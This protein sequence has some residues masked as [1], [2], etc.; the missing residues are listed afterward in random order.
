MTPAVA[1]GLSGPRTILS[2]FPKEQFLELK[3]QGITRYVLPAASKDNP[4]TLKVNDTFAWNRNWGVDEVVFFQQPVSAQVVAENLVHVWAA[5]MVGSKQGFGPGIM[6]IAGD[7]PTEEELE[8]VR[9][10]QEEFFNFLINTADDYEQKGE[11]HMI[12]DVH[13]KAAEWMGVQGRSWA[14]AMREKRYIPCPECQEDILEGARKCKH[15]QSV[16]VQSYIEPIAPP[17]QES[18]APPR[19]QAIKA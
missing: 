7:T 14:K 5:S 12:T 17:V 15:C 16:L 11:R 6:I 18:K 9:N 1:P 10:R 13:R 8:T 19:P 3:H 2:I 4:V